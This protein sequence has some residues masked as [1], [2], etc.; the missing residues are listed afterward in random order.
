[1]SA[2]VW[3]AA[4]S[5]RTAHLRK[6]GVR[7]AKTRDEET[8]IEALNLGFEAP[9]AHILGS[10]SCEERL[11][12]PEGCA[13]MIIGKKGE[14]LK[15]IEQRYKVTAKVEEGD[16]GAKYVIIKGTRPNDVAEAVRELDFAADTIEVPSEMVAWLCGRGGRHLK[17]IR[18]LSG[19][20]VL[21]I[22]RPDEGDRP[23]EGGKSGKSKEASVPGG[24]EQ[25]QGPCHLEMRGIRESV[26]D[27]RLCL[28]AH[29]SYYPV[30]IEMDEVEQQLNEQ[31]SEAQAQLGR[32][33]GSGARKNNGE[34]SSVGERKAIGAG[35]TTRQSNK[36]E[37]GGG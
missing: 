23:E 32:R 10:G 13:G 21:R 15:G 5:R 28:E 8:L 31:I 6:K 12:I 19:V 22:R 26:A 24:A 36:K 4:E 14:R 27:A 33:V 16:A 35:S 34:R 37:H 30:F 2:Y 9:P 17:L 3:Q 20:S 18:D 29:M 1:M 7:E 11:E 25:P